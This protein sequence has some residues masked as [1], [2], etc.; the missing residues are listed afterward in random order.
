MAKKDHPSGKQ[1]RKALKNYM[2]DEDNS[3]H[4]LVSNAKLK[5]LAKTLD[6]SIRVDK[7]LH[8][9]VCKL[10]AKRLVE[11]MERTYDNKRG[12]IRPSDL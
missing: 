1:L 2:T 8:F 5:E 12:T 11:A 3:P 4:R 7:E 9:A 6:P 10:V